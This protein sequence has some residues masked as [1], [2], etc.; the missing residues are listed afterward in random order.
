[1]RMCL[2]CFRCWQAPLEITPPALA[3]AGSVGPPQP[4]AGRL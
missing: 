2:D 1:L 4:T 3:T